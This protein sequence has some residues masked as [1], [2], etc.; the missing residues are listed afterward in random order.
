MAHHDAAGVGVALGQR[1]DDDFGQRAAR[2]VAAF[3]FIP[4]NDNHAVVLVGLRSHDLRND[5]RE[6]IVALRNVSR[7]AGVMRA[8]I[9]EAAAQRAVRVVVLVGRDPVVTSDRIVGEVVK[10]LRQRINILELACRERT[11]SDCVSR[12][13]CIA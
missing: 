13:N 6:E 4:P 5:L 12:H 7:V 8:V 2:V 3:S 9:S 11:P 1:R 10:Q